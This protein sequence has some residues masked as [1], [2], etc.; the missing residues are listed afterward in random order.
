MRQ[1]QKPKYSFDIDVDF[2]TDRY[3]PRWGAW[4][5]IQTYGN[6]L[7][8][9]LENICGAIDD[10]DGGELYCGPCDEDWAIELITE[11]YYGRHDKHRES[12]ETFGDFLARMDK[13]KSKAPDIMDAA[14]AHLDGHHE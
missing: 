5:N 12:H 11:A 8:E 2:E 10:Q 3:C 13:D 14:D 1:S 9:L 7:E 6:D 4:S